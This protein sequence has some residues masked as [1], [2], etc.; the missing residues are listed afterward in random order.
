[1]Y[2]CHICGSFLGTISWRKKNELHI[3][4][5]SPSQVGQIR[6]FQ[7]SH[8]CPLIQGGFSLSEITGTILNAENNAQVY[9]VM[10][11]MS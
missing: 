11:L 5:S 2:L 8:L 7:P 4:I 10:E 6:W 9:T 3:T 1:M